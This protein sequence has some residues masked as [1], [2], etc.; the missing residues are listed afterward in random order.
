MFEA[1]EGVALETSCANGSLLTPAMSDPWNAP[2]VYRLLAASLFDPSSPMKLHP[3]AIP[4]L[5]K[6]GVRF[7]RNSTLARYRAATRSNYRLA[8]YSVERTRELRDRL[9]LQYD[10]A[11]VGSMKLFR[12]RASFERSLALARLLEPLGLRCEVLDRDGAVSMEPAL[13]SIREQIVSALRFPDDECGDA[14]KFCEALAQVLPLTGG[15]LLTGTRVSAL[16]VENGRAIGVITD[17]GLHRAAAVV[18]AAGNATPRLVRPL[19]ISLA[20]RPVKGY[21]VTIDASRVEGRPL[22]PVIDDD[23]HAAVVPIGTRLRVAGTAEFAG[24]DTTLREERIA[25][26]HTLLATVYPAIAQ[27]IDHANVEKWAA[28]R[29]VSADGLPFIGATRVR[30]LF[31]NAG[32]GHLGWTLAVGSAHL[33]ADAITGE[34]SA[35]DPAAYCAN[36]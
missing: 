14:R 8:R 22:I 5:L 9:G 36:R 11:A 10:A 18:A 2:G 16:A 17:K 15:T 1:R 30:N 29:P 25:A 28:L 24:M 26:L 21:T 20:I 35:I 33:V 13:L 19:G 7:L 34:R 32:H 27:S 6:W 12:C 23:S 3:A 4:S 31:V